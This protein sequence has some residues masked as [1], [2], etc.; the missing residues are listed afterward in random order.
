MNLWP[1]VVAPWQ[2]SL[3]GGFMKRVVWVLP[4]LLLACFP[5]KADSVPSTVQI[6]INVSFTYPPLNP[7]LTTATENFQASYQL[8]N[9]GSSPV[10]T[11]DPFNDPIGGNY[12]LVPGS[13]T[14]S[15]LGPLGPFTIADAGPAA[16]FFN[17]D[18]SSTFPTDQIQIEFQLQP[19]IWKVPGT[20]NAISNVDLYLQPS[21]S[22]QGVIFG[23]GN[24]VV[25]GV[26]EPGTAALLVTGMVGLLA[27]LCAGFLKRES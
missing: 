19:N 3:S 22:T 4:L 25:T 27:S 14:F 20:Y 10:F 17:F 12:I 6:T 1:T 7:V 13:M 9:I 26:P 11:G 8:E 23:D 5:A 24:V 21:V 15:T 18:D 2:I 16:N